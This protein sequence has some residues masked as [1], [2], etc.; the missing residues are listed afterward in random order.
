MVTEDYRHL[1]QVVQSVR[2]QVQQGTF[3]AD[4]FDR[5]IDR[6]V[7]AIRSSPGGSTDFDHQLFVDRCHGKAP[8]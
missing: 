8:L 4:E 6:M 3:P 5:L 2:F 7:W 1:A